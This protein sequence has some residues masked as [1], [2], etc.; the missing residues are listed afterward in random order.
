VNVYLVGGAVRDRLLGLPIK[1]RDW[2]VVGSTPEEMLSKGYRQ[3]GKDFP[4]FLHPQTN[5]EYALARTERKISKGYKGFSIYADPKVTLAEDLIRRDLDAC[6]L[7]RLETSQGYRDFVTAVADELQVV[8]SLRVR[9]GL[10]L[11]LSPCV[12]GHDR[13][14]GNHAPAA[15]SDS[16]D[17]SGLSSQLRR[18]AAGEEHDEA[19]THQR[20]LKHPDPRFLVQ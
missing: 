10:V 16:A 3:V 17:L 6:G 13:C 7:E 12:D 8:I 19:Y 15:V 5:E 20:A 9:R 4:V 2:V 14:A 18:R 11:I 1:E